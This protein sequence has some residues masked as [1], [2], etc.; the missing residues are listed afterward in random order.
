MKPIA[1]FLPAAALVLCGFSAPDA[2][3][4]DVPSA[5]VAR[6]QPVSDTYF[7]ET[8]VDR[9]RWMEDAKDPDWLPYLRGQDAHARA[10]L[11]ALPGHDAL[12]KRI[13]RLSGDSAATGDIQR[14]GHR[15]FY[16]QRPAGANNF[17][18]YVRSGDPRRG[19]DRLLVDPTTLDSPGRHVSLDWWAPSPDGR[20]LVYGLSSDGSEDST[21]HVMKVDTGAELPERIANTEVAS[22]SWLP[23]ASGFFYNQLTGGVGTPERY[24]DSKLRFH[25]LGSDPATDPVIMARGLD[26]AVAYDRIQMPT[27]I[28]PRGSD[29]AVLVLADVRNER[30]LLVAPLADAVTA[31]AH[32]QP[33]ADFVDEVTDFALVGDDLYLLAAKGHPRGRVLLTSARAP[34]IATASEVVPESAL[35][36]KEIVRARDGLYLRSLEGGLARLQVMESVAGKTRVRMVPLPYDGTIRQVEGDPGEAGV[37]VQMTSWLKPPAVLALDARGRAQ[38]TGIS[39]PSRIDTRPY[40]SERRFATAKD[41]TRVPYD[42]VYRK[43]LKHDGHAP[44]FISAY[45]SYGATGYPPAFNA[46]TL[47]LIDQGAIV[48]YAAVRGGGEYG[49]E[50]HRAGQLENKPNT[51]RDLIAVC[52]D[53]VA[54]GDTA[55]A[56]LA[57][58]GRSAGGITVGRALTERPDL[59]AAVVSGVGWHDPLRY[60]VEQDGYGE[61]PEWGAIADPAGYRALKAIDS[62]QAVV[63]GTKYPAVLLT[64]GVS[65]PRVAPFHVAKMAA[66]LQAATSSGNPVLLR[67]DFDAGHGIGSTRA[68]ADAEAADT[69]AFILWQT[70]GGATKQKN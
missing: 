66:R 39:P 22:P 16:L 27:V 62:Y 18:L 65:D 35:V 63:D 69:Y 57:I 58:G 45:G 70:R 51:W 68:Q 38:D 10:V 8:L 17:K 53:L 4:A 11:A 28:V 60:V 56:H 42:I 48:G 55:P 19:P 23:D 15:L 59:F 67:V 41:G 47:V 29:R 6:V 5:P 37:I 3:A 32:W 31:K 25:R 12:L 43:G 14:A 33:V 24:L 54:R 50:W 40:T 36:L 21:L 30:R 49:R 20:L 2:N 46:R 61:E 52:E 7:G 64:T 44:A 1:L 26:P 9:Y 13:Q 34:D